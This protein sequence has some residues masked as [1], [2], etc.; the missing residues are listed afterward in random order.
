MSEGYISN[1]NILFN[2]L[3][4]ICELEQD[5][6]VSLNV[7]KKYVDKLQTPAILRHLIKTLNYMLMMCYTL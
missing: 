5:L 3:M 1:I 6:L 7:R 2:E 4:N